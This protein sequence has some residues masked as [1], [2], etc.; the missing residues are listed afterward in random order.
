M[1]QAQAEVRG[2]RAVQVELERLIAERPSFHAW[3]DGSP[4]NC[5]PSRGCCEPRVLRF[6]VHS[7]MPMGRA[8]RERDS[9]IAEP[10]GRLLAQF[11]HWARCSC[12][13]GASS[14]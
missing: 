8:K 7:G 5:S 9:Q 6:N 4:A 10:R 11:R 2:S 14:L 3:P 1:I 12:V 13:A